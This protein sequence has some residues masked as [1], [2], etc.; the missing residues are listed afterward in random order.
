[1][2]K[3]NTLLLTVLLLLLLL[4]GCQ[5][6]REVIELDGFS[7]ELKETIRREYGLTIPDS[8]VFDHGQMIFPLR[9]SSL[10]MVFRVPENDLAKCMDAEWQAGNASGSVDGVAAE[11]AFW[12]KG[13]E[14]TACLYVMPPK[15]GEVIVWLDGEKPSKKWLRV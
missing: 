8:A 3:T 15:H 13:Q 7:P 9:N 6:C 1:M 10:Q 14:R 11:K 2:I 4:C 5:Y 12:R